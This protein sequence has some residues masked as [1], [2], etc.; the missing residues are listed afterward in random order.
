MQQFDRYLK[1]EACYGVKINS[2]WA[3]VYLYL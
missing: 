2:T 1:M 3:I